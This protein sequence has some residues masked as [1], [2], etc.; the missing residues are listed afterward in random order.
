MDAYELGDVEAFIWKLCDGRCSVE[1]ISSQ[2][3]HEYNVTDEVAFADTRA[4]ISQLESAG[5]LE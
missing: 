1:D 5:L 4:F 3:A 2:L